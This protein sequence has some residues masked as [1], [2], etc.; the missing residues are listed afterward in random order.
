[1]SPARVLAV[2]NADG[3]LATGD[4]Q[5]SLAVSSVEGAVAGVAEA[6]RSKGHEV[7]ILA[8]PNDPREVLEF[9]AGFDCDV[10]FNLVESLAGDAR[11]EAH[12]AACLELR[13]I[14]YTGNRPF[15]LALCLQKPMARAVLAAHGVEIARGAVLQRGDEPLEGLAYPLI[16]KPSR[17]DASHGIALE[18]V[19]RDPRALRERARFV[20]ERYAQPALVEEFIAGREFNVGLIEG[21]KA[22]DPPRVLSL[23]EIDFTGYPA[24]E[25]QMVTYGAKWIEGSPEWNGTRSVDPTLDPALDRRIREASLGAWRALG[26]AGYARVDLRAEVGGAGRLAVIDVNSNPDLSPE[27]G[28]ALTVVR[29]GLPYAEFIDSILGFALRRAPART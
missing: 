17:E 5:D 13:G 10:V 28:F 19:V 21:P 26:L 8:A 23:S 14:P 3:N 2:Y 4:A 16:V 25:P 29:N 24:G 7:R 6:L 15:T 12:F 11:A 18:S 20:I 1:V 9:V 22:G 27:A